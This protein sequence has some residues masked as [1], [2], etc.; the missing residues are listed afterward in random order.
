MIKK[1]RLLIVQ[2]CEKNWCEVE[3]DDFNGWIKND[4][5]WGLIKISR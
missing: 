3:T 2:K 1:G 4:D 5:L